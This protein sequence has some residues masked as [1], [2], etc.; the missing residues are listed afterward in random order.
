MKQ[1]TIKKIKEITTNTFYQLL[2]VYTA[3]I[4]LI[5]INLFSEYTYHF[6]IFAILLA[7]LGIT[8]ISTDKTDHHNPPSQP[9]KKH[10]SKKTTKIIHSLLF[11]LAIVLILLFRTIP[12]INNSIP[13]GYDTGI[14]K[15]GIEHGLQNLDNWILQGGLEPGFLYIVTF[16]HTFLSSQFM[17]TWLFVISTAILGV[18]IYILTKK[19]TDKNTAL[20]T[21]LIYSVSIIQFKVFTYLYYKNI[22]A[23]ITMLFALYF[24]EK[25]ELRNRIFFII[26]A[27]LTGI[28]HRPTFFIFILAYITLSIKN[29]KNWKRNLIN[30]LIILA[31]TLL[32]Y[33]PDFLPAIT[34]MILPVANSLIQPGN[35]SGT[36][37]NFLTYQFSTLAYLPFAVLGFFIL[38]KKKQFNFLFFLTAIAG[39]IVYFQLFFFNR[40]IIYLDIFLIILASLGFSQ[41]IKNKKRLGTII[42]V[43]L[44]VALA[45]PTYQESI[46]TKSLISQDQLILIQKLNQTELNSSVISISSEYSTWILAYSNREIIAPGLFDEDNWTKQQWGQFWTS[47]SKNETRTLFSVYSKPIYLFAGTK[48]FNNPCFSTY[49]EQNQN[50]LYKYT[51]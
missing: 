37:I 15:Y 50:K 6:E 47:T 33:L 4:L 21:I 51:C 12:Y 29:Y 41:L 2:V 1:E 17:L 7:V 8:I 19:Y 5:S 27:I 3:L 11:I 16:L 44:L 9:T 26:L 20:I 30:I 32:F 38:I 13:I 49:L 40:F 23:L 43:I 42:L 48:T 46:N 36:F 28:I 35:S 24:Y 39:I 25:P 22:L 18:A 10:L 45:I 34:S 14:Y 31:I